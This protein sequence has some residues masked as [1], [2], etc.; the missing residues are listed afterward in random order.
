MPMK[1]AADS[2]GEVLAALRSRIE[3]LAPGQAVDV[4]DLRRADPFGPDAFAAL[5]RRFGLVDHVNGEWRQDKQP[6]WTP[7]WIA[8]AD[9]KRCADLFEAAFGYRMDERLWRWKYRDAEPLGVGVWQG[10]RL[11]AFYGGMPRD[12]LV[13]GRAASAVQIGDVMVEPSER[14]VMT[15]SGPFQIAAST[16]LERRIGHGRPHLLGFGF[17]TA[18]ALQVAQ[19]LGLYAEVDR[20]TQIT[21]T[22][23]TNWR[24]R[25]GRRLKDA[26]RADAAIVNRLWDRMARDF[27]DSI[28]GVRNWNYIEARYLQ[29]PTVEYRCLLLRR[30]FGAAQALIVLRPLEDGQAE[31]IDIVGPRASFEAAVSAARHWAAGHGATRVRAWITASHAA[32]LDFQSA[33]AAPLDLVVPTNVW[34]PGPAV[35]DVRGHWWLMAGDTDFR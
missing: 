30:L 17:P 27:A 4:D 16:F 13:R 2:T 15:R 12:V 18:K 24:H 20:I 14:G 29:H 5:A 34:S 7:G 3:H 22:A 32:A 6:R 8:P 33:E 35:D 11:V 19:R 28:L 9:E 21:W 10:D 25:I 1:G 31:L 23:G 26:T